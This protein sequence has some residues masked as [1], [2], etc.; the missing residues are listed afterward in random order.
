[1]QVDLAAV[2]NRNGGSPGRGSSRSSSIPHRAARQAHPTRHDC[3]EHAVQGRGVVIDDPVADIAI[4]AH[5]TSLGASPHGR[6]KR[7][8]LFKCRTSTGSSLSNRHSPHRES[9]ARPARRSLCCSRPRLLP[10]D[11]REHVLDAGPRP[12][13]RGAGL[14]RGRP[15]RTPAARMRSHIPAASRRCRCGSRSVARLPDV[16]VRQ[17]YWGALVHDIGELDVPEPILDRPGPLATIERQHVDLHPGSGRAGWRAP[18]DCRR[19]SRTRAGTTSASTAPAIRTAAAGTRCR[20]RSRSWPC[21]TAG[22][23]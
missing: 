20:S 2:A 9:R 21:A 6:P 16:E 12:R 1:M 19:W 14:A 8:G 17:V 23:R 5:T 3:V 10:K 18:R 7:V 11:K 15:A 4:A 22:T 13:R